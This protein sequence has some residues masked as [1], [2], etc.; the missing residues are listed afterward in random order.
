[1]CLVRQSIKEF[2]S[3]F[4]LPHRSVLLE[5]GTLSLP[6]EFP[7]PCRCSF[8]L[9]SFPNCE[10]WLFFSERRCQYFHS[11]SPECSSY[12]IN[13]QLF[14]T[15]I[16]L[17]HT[18]LE[19]NWTKQLYPL[20]QKSS[21]WCHFRILKKNKTKKKPRTVLAQQNWPAWNL[22]YYSIPKTMDFLQLRITKK[23]VSMNRTPGKNELAKFN[24]EC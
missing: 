11:I 13:G 7:Y 9:K 16:L 1:M 18:A 12:K 10:E 19:T 24:S 14:L 20:L 17:Q 15:A 3:K 23:P 22:H 5:R 4:S 2:Q 21:I 6:L 8:P